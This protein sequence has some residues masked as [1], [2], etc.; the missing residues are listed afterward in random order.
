MFA[1]TKVVNNLYL[2]KY[3][4]E[5]AWGMVP[6]YVLFLLK[7][8]RNVGVGSGVYKQIMDTML[9]VPATDESGKKVHIS[10]IDSIEV[11]T[12]LFT[13]KRIYAIHTIRTETYKG[14]K[15][16]PTYKEGGKGLTYSTS[17][18]VPVKGY[19]NLCGYDKIYW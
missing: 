5:E 17:I 18:Y 7:Q 4:V 6:K 12:K 2:V 8:L 16:E 3:L 10:V 9:Y 13:L 11:A 1:K 14:N 15:F 19:N